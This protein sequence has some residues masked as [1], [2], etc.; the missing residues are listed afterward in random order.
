LKIT[1][2][3]SPDSRIARRT[4][5]SFGRHVATMHLPV[6]SGLTPRRFSV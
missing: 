5:V 2:K 1:C 4:L 3:S 6:S